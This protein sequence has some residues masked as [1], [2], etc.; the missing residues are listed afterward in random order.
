MWVVDA[1][2][3]IDLII[4]QWK[5]CISAIESEIRGFDQLSVIFVAVALTINN[6]G[7]I[8]GGIR[9]LIHIAKYGQR[10]K[11]K[12]MFTLKIRLFIQHEAVEDF[13]SFY[14]SD[15]KDIFFSSWCYI[16]FKHKLSCAFHSSKCF[17]A[18]TNTIQNRKSWHVFY[19][20][21]QCK[22]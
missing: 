21:K 22:A 9:F 8:R 13:F 5:Q 11:Y 1:K 4:V 14:A 18:Q 20:I 7:L 3:T 2:I 17:I 12:K 10:L 6:K 15:K 19:Y 16:L